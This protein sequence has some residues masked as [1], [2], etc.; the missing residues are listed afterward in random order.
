MPRVIYFTATTL[1]GFIADENNSL[2]WLFEVPEGP[3]DGS[4]EPFIA[5]IGALVMG[6]TTYE[7]VLAHEELVT[8]PEKWHAFYGDRPCWVFTH[9]ELPAIP[10]VT[11]HFVCGD[12]AEVY[13]EIAAGAGERD[14]W[15]VG[16]GD[17]VGQFDDAG[18]LDELQLGVCPVTLGAGAPLLPRRISSQRLT[19][20]DVRRAGQQAR[21]VLDVARQA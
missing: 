21:L 8:H 20:R 11:L 17:L 9:R 6:A 1:D 15:V 7:W 14:I 19:L 2:E 13:D 16:G 12:V 4:W 3:D 5:G 18:H 10:G